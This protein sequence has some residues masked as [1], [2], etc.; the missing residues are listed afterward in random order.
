MTTAHT[1]I[2]AQREQIS[3]LLT[4]IERVRE[5]TDEWIDAAND[6]VEVTDSAVT[7]YYCAGLIR[8]ALN[9]GA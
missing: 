1:V 9:E 4:V 6:A 5:L 2:A 8:R 7:R 3:D